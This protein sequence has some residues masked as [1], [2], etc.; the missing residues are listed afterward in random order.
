MILVVQS[1]EPKDSHRDRWFCRWRRRFVITCLPAQHTW[2]LCV[3][4]NQRR[5][6]IVILVLLFILSFRSKG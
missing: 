1:T 6:V 5:H 2:G 4:C 3:S